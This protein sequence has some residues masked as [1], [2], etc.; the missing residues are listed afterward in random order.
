MQ[1]HF[2]LFKFHYFSNII[3]I[4]K[5]HIKKAFIC[6]GIAKYCVDHGALKNFVDHGAFKNFCFPSKMLLLSPLIP[7]CLVVS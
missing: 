4:F 3:S 1:L 6:V 5:I 2:L 7:L